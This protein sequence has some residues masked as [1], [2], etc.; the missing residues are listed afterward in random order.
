MPKYQITIEF[1]DAIQCMEFMD[2]YASLNPIA[3]V[4]EDGSGDREV[5]G[6]AQV[7][8]TRNPGIRADPIIPSKP[9]GITSR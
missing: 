1:D 5:T 8:E 2:E 3:K 7:P 6:D 4:I 9:K